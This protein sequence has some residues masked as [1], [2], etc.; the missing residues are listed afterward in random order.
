MRL[1]STILFVCLFGCTAQAQVRGR[2]DARN[3]RPPGPSLILPFTETG[4]MFE[5]DANT[6]ANVIWQTTQVNY[7]LESETICTSPWVLTGPGGC[8][9]DDSGTLD[10]VIANNNTVA[11]QQTLIPTA[12][13]TSFTIS[14]QIENPYI[15]TNSTIG[16]GCDNGDVT[17]CT[18]HGAD[19]T[20]DSTTVSNICLGR[21]R[22]L[23]ATRKH[24]HVAWSCTV[25]NSTATIRLHPLDYAVSPGGGASLFG[26][27]DLVAGIDF[28]APYVATTTTAVVTSGINDLKGNAWTMNGTVP[29]REP[30]VSPFIPGLEGA[31]VYSDA[32]YYSLADDTMEWAGDWSVTGTMSFTAL[33]GARVFASKGNATSG[34]ACYVNGNTASIF[35]YDGASKTAATAAGTVV[36]GPNI[37]TCG[38]AGGTCYVRANAGAAATVACGTM[39][40]AAGQGARIGRSGV[41]GQAMTAGVTYKVIASTTPYSDALHDARFNRTYG[42]LGTKSEVVSLTRATPATIDVNGIVW[43]IAP[44]VPRV[45]ERGLWVEQARTN[46]V[47][48]SGGFCSAGAAIAPWA[49]VGGSATCTADTAVAPDGITLAD[50]VSNSV[51]TSGVAQAITTATLASTAYS[52]WMRKAAGGTATLFNRCIAGT[53]TTCTCARIDGGA[54]TTNINGAD[55]QVRYTSLPPGAWIRGW[56]IATCSAA[57][58]SWQVFFFPG[59][60]G[61]STGTAEFWGVQNEVSPDVTTYIPTAGSAVARNADQATVPTPSGFKGPAWCAEATYY[62]DWTVA[63]QREFWSNGIISQANTARLYSIGASTK[64]IETYDGA[65]ATRINAFTATGSGWLSFGLRASNT[66]SGVGIAY[67]DGAIR[68]M[69][70]SGAGSGLM[71]VWATPIYLGDIQQNDTEILNGAI[72]NF[73][74][75]PSATCR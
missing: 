25:P 75:V 16:G 3:V 73:K 15:S 9:A 56:A 44:G 34:W 12:P 30:T 4:S 74:L 17:F 36:T 55:C 43:S 39:T 20:P 1:I 48:Q 10:R 41:A 62:R 28:D 27:I 22:N 51:S 14:A 58:T 70:P 38:K 13:S 11:L 18:C 23:D 29:Q 72:K 42:N 8:V 26:E 65:A 63:A 52:G 6:V 54:C 7:A 66:S 69:T 57:T 50:Q 32:N 67:V 53:V 2:T 71:D 24:V 59:D 49:L 40:S 35:V 5:E 60:Y 46:Y 31:G 61:V 21:F 68:S 47:L 37:I 33:S 19:C 64:R 45:N